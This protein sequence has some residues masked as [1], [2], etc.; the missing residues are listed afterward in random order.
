MRRYSFDPK[1][2][3]EELRFKSKMKRL[4]QTEKEATLRVVP[5]EV[6][7][8][9]HKYGYSIYYSGGYAAFRNYK[10]PRERFVFKLLV[11]QKGY[12]EIKHQIKHYHAMLGNMW[13]TE[14]AYYELPDLELKLMHHTQYL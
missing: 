6:V 4:K 11:D 2:Y 1:A 14:L 9:F 10:I 5:V 3:A 7:E 12:W 8:L 13:N